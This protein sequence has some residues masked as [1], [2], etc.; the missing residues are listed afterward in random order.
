MGEEG[1]LTSRHLG[2]IASRVLILGVILSFGGTWARAQRRSYD[3]QR[4]EIGTQYTYLNLRTDQIACFNCRTNNSGVG[5]VLTF[6]LAP[7]LGFDSAINAFPEQGTGTVNGGQITQGL[8]GFRSGFASER[9][10]LF[11]KT[12]FGFTRF[13]NVL[14]P[15]APIFGPGGTV[16]PETP[17]SQTLFTTD[18]GTIFEFRPS[19]RVA[20]RVDIGDTVI[21]YPAISGLTTSFYRSNFQVSSGLVFR[22]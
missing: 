8:F 9:F 17:G 16:I 13:G 18:V 14:I 15:G 19:S 5:A 6:N 12:R 10:G 7:F 20:F 22:F 3:F 2:H 1:I 21:R 4:I 11:G